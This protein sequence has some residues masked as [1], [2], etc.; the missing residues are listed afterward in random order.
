[1]A[2]L[3]VPVRALELHDLLIYRQAGKRRRV[4][5]KTLKIDNFGADAVDN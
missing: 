1:M 2:R 4:S 3:R 5:Y